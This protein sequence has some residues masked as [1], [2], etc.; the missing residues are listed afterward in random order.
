M[1][2][3]VKRKFIYEPKLPLSGAPIKFENGYS[4]E[5]DDDGWFRLVDPKGEGE[6]THY[7]GIALSS[8]NQFFAV[9]GY[10]GTSGEVIG[11]EPLA[12][13]KAE[14]LYRFEEIKRSS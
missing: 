2:E 8:D 12:G 4:Y 13:L 3:N 5:M 10:F 6:W 7:A 1:S 14:T 11:R 9:S